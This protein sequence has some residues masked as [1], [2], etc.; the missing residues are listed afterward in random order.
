M[1]VRAMGMLELDKDAQSRVL[2]Y[3]M[4]RY[5]AEGKVA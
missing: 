4:G 1:L 5:C 2:E 3:L